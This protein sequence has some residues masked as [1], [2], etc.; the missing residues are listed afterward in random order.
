VSAGSIP[1]IEPL[2]A[3]LDLLPGP[4]VLMTPGAGH[5]L[6]ANRAAHAL[7]GGTFPLAET[8]E[9][10]EAAFRLYEPDGTPMP[11]ERAPAMRASRGEKLVNVPVDWHTPGNG[12]RSLIVSGDT[13]AGPDGNPI[14]MVTF[15][16]VT[17]L[18]SAERSERRVRQELTAIL[19]NVADAVV[20]QSTRGEILFA[21]SAAVRLLGYET[22]EAMREAT[23]EERMAR[24]SFLDE[25][26]QPVRMES[27]PG[28]R[29]M[30]GEEP[31]PMT[32]RFR[33]PAGGG[34]RWARFKA[35]PLRDEKGG[36]RMAISV[37]EDVTEI[38][39]AEQEQRF[40]ADAGRVL[41][42]SLDYE[43]TLRTVAALA[44]PEI[45]DWCVVD[46]ASPDGYERVALAHAD[47]AR[48]RWVEEISRRYPPDKNAPT[49]VPQVLRSG[50][51]EHYPHIPEELLEAGAQDEEHL[52][53]I[54]EV[55][56]VSAMVVPIVSAGRT[57]G[58]IT[59]V[60]AESGRRFGEPEL[61]LAEELGLR[62]G[63]AIENARLYRQR[64]EIA[65]TLQSSLLPPE[66]PEIEHLE[67]AAMYRPAGE[68]FDVGG[69]FY[70]LF[71]TGEDHWYAVCGDVVGKG[72]EAAATTAMV[73][74]TVRAAAVDAGST[75]SSILQALNM[76][77]LRQGGGSLRFCT[78]AIVRL[79]VV[80]DR[81]LASAA[82]AGHPLPRVVRAGGTIERL[83]AP[84]T[85]V[86]VTPDL[87]LEELQAT[88]GLGDSILIF[89]DGIVEAQ[90]PEVIWSMEDVDAAL[91]AL[92]GRP[93]IDLVTGF[94]AAAVGE[95]GAPLRDDLAVLALRVR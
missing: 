63:I 55:G 85:L 26:R 40:L 27:F 56:M 74:Y 82:S 58:A 50:Q 79:D 84:G 80:G 87:D 20:A 90:A 39:Q 33:P 78:L 10:F 72:P 67:A 61:S 9:E 59:M 46:L 44:V 65:Q 6:F 30:R 95:S 86:G 71:S 18:R 2:T 51:A 36:V 31:E 16:D 42:S 5:F 23:P 66:L 45:A 15:E 8:P 48:I 75:P 91:R 47:P 4:A 21:N 52:R 12:W 89:T 57:L 81:V 38:K 62:A 35:R 43:R 88:L 3:V 70:D 92:V 11:V 29:A 76:A 49:G 37:I 19:E 77:M 17:D 22:L 25:M 28:R 60:T 93:L 73:R 24:M 53:L 41:A 1:N 69:D 54:R 13:V 14:V 83:G 32:V 94:T 64:S 34:E 68:G 7:A